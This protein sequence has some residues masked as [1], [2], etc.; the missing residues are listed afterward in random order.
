[1]GGTTGCLVERVLVLGEVGLGDRHGLRADLLRGRLA[2]ERVVGLLDALRADVGRL[3][4]DQAL[5]RAVLE[6]LDLL[7][8]GVEA[9]DLD[10][11]AGLAGTGR[12]TLGGEQVGAEDAL[13][14]RVLLERGLH[15]GGGDLGLVVG[16]LAPDVVEAGRLGAVDEALLARVRRRD[17]RLDVDHEDLALAADQLGQRRRRGLAAGQVVRGDLRDG[18]VGLVERGVDEH[19]LDA[20]VGHLLDRGVERLGVR[21]RD[22]HR[23]GLL[24]GDRVDDRRLLRGVELLRALE[25][26]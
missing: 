18:H 7:G 12:R 2:G 3:L 6:V 16:V 17:A 23:V 25:V 4:G 11:G 20:L 15:L 1:M 21:R 13:E 10:L 8:T 22:Q 24:G 26:E 19:D 5:H 14:V 9:D